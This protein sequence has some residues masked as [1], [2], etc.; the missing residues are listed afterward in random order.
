MKRSVQFWMALLLAVPTAG[1][2][3]ANGES[4]ENEASDLDRVTVTGSRIAGIDVEGSQ[5]LR[6]IDR[7]ELDESGANNLIDYLETLSLTG[8]GE[9]TFT[10]RTAGALSTSSPVG[11]AQVSLRGLGTSSTLTLLNGRR[12]AVASFANNQES[13]VDINTIPMAAV[14]RVEVLPSGASAIYGADAVAGVV[15]VILRDDFE[16]FEISAGYGNSHASSNDARYD[17]NLIGGFSGER[18]RSIVILDYFRRE[19]LF[20]RDRPET[21]FEIRPAQQ[22]LYPSFNDLF[23]MWDDITEKPEDGGCPADQFV[24]DGVFGEYCELNRGQ[25]VATRDQFESWSATGLF[26][27]DINEDLEWFNELSFVRVESRGTSSPAPF[28]RIPV[29]PERPDWP[30]GLVNDIVAE[31]GVDDFSEFFGFPIFAWGAFPDP[32]QVEVQTDNLRLVSGLRGEL[33]SWEWESA[34][35]YGKS[36]ST[37][38]GVA[39]LYRTL[40]FRQAMLGNLC[41]DGSFGG[42]WDDVLS[43]NPQFVG[44]PSCEDL[45]LQTVYYNPF[46]GQA[47]Q[48]PLVEDLLRTEAI[49]RGESEMWSFDYRTSGEIF[50][51]ANG[52]W[53]MGAFGYEFRYEDIFD[54]PSPEARSTADNPEPTLRF[55][56]TEAQATRRQNAAYAEFFV[57]LAERFE[58]QLAG[59]F[60]HYD[61]FGSDFN[62]KIAF[63]WQPLEQLIFRGSWS[64]SFRA[65]SL[66]QSGAGV[67]L[68]SYSVPCDRV[69]EACGGEDSG[70]NAI[71]TELLGNP[72]LAPETAENIGLGFAWQIDRNTNLTV[73]YWYIDHE[74]LVGIDDLDFILRALEGQFPVVDLDAGDEFLPQGQAGLIF[75]GGSLIQAN[76]PLQNFGYQRTDGIDFSLTRHFDLGRYGT[77][78]LVADATRLNRFDRELSPTSGK[79][80]LAGEWRYPRW[81]ADLSLR[82]RQGDWR[83]R[84]GARYVGNYKDDLEGL[85]QDVLDRFD[86]TPESDID[87]GSWLTFNLNLSYD[88]TQN[89]WVSF[90]VENL[91]DRSPP[92]VFGSAAGVDFINHNTMGRFYQLR[93]THRIW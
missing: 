81:L 2:H 1:I 41:S 52:R 59:R 51:M 66:A 75:E 5:P 32:R 15:N 13:F 29:D 86:L 49:R 11:S 35:S 64:T 50:E 36:E 4:E 69:P 20:D 82:W 10:T 39:G 40:E 46:F 18:H 61:D 26:N 21:R 55:S 28:S 85:R 84:L 71:D 80:S 53:L 54:N 77:M 38:T 25:F 87:V 16:G 34:V 24:G 76:V 33:G 60:D 31:G 19:P 17:I 93:Y 63:R 8:G 30:Q 67:T 92:F 79:E 48:D 68:S 78:R 89:S 9:G 62:P 90:N 72:D 74:N 43:R 6:I 56:F 57:P 73:D 7:E 58:L 88:I 23:L 14:E 45:G 22:G 65:P 12:I 70:A 47:E 42:R 83:T 27:F 3:A 91:F 44:G 37:Q